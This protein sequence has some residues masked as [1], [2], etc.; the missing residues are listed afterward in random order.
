MI[1]Y[2]V[3]R[4]LYGALVLF[5]VNLLTFLLFFA[6][7]TPD[8]MARLNLGGK[9]ITPEAVEAWKAAH[10]YDLP[11]FVNETAEGTEKFTETLFWRKSVPMLALDFGTSDSGRDIAAEI[12]TRSVPSLLL[13]VPTFVLGLLVLV[14]WSLVVVLF[15]RTAFEAAAVGLSVVLMSVSSLFYVILGQWLFGKVM[16]LVPVSGWASDE[17][18][19]VFLLLPV[20]LGILSRL[21]SDTLLYRALFLEEME[22]DYV[23]LARMKGLTEERILFG[24]V[25]RNASLPIITSSVA[26]IPMLFMGSLI[27][28]SF[29]GIPGLGSYTIDALNAQDFSV[30]RAMVFLGTVAYVVGLILTD[31]VYTWAD[32]RIRLGRA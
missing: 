28:E 23:R 29:F 26:M 6:V 27:M 3:R 16:R 24:H 1:A 32:P 10:G 2:L 21:G 13:A 7:N 20:A 12:R 19:F 8:D 31:I 15:R 11:L 25:L 9:R 14:T 18:A 22:K 17:G 5:G 4:V 30:V